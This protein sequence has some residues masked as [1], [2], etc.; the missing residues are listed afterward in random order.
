MSRHLK[1]FG[2]GTEIESLEP[3]AYQFGLFRLLVDVYLPFLGGGTSTFRRIGS[4]LG[5]VVFATRKLRALPDG[6]IIDCLI[7]SGGVCDRSLILEVP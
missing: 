4:K 6:G 3:G 5:S 1:L 7:Y 2:G